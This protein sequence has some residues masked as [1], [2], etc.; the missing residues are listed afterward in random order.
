M[1][2]CELGL[3]LQLRREYDR[4][5][6]ECGAAK[7]GDSW[8]SRAELR[9]MQDRIDGLR[10]TW[11]ERIRFRSVHPRGLITDPVWS[12]RLAFLRNFD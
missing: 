7:P 12:V 8:K 10:E 9:L 1:R 3:L 11:M 5:V 6:F 2:P 4:L